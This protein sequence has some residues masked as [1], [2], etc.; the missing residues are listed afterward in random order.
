MKH[1]KDFTIHF[2]GIKGVGMTAL[3]ILVSEAGFPVTGS[4]IKDTFIT[5]LALKKAGIL[6]QEGFSEERVKQA[7]LVITT[8]AH[9][10]YNNPE[11][12]AAKAN[13]ITVWSQGEAV[14]KFMDGTLLSENPFVGISILGTH[15]KTTTTAMIATILRESRLDPSYVIGTSDI[16]S[17]PTPGHFGKGEYFVAE[18]DEYATEPNS[19]KTAKFLWQHPKIAVVTNIEMDHPDV[20]ANI[21]ELSDAFGMFINRLPEDGLLVACGDDEIIAKLLRDAPCPVRT[22]GFSPNN[23]Y[24]IKRVTVSGDQT[25]FRA[26]GMGIDLGDFRLQVSGEHNALNALAACVV[27][28]E[29]GQNIEIVRKAVSAFQGS[30][31]RMEKIGILPS[32]ATLYDDY[33]HHPTEITKTLHAFRQMHPRGKI[34]CIFQPHT[35]SRTQKL[36]DQFTTSFSDIDAVLLIDIYAS[37]REKTNKEVSSQAL[38]AAMQRLHKDTRFVADTTQLPDMLAKYW[39]REG[40]V[41]ITMG[42]G[43]VYKLH[44]LLLYS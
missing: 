18:A 20:Y 24:V 32:G 19:D 38:A 9:G 42:A 1:K 15:G 21:D 6:V 39:L 25:F 29:I 31:R 10:G 41:V 16:T 40:D 12:V 35:Y 11:V 30:K 23:D 3:A 13:G 28:L 26:V 2:V 34:V 27:G 4:D 8:G 36:F 22:Y 5:D 37:L 17:L 33:A 43:D 7:S 14:G 44:E